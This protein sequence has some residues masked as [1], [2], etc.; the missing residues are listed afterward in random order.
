M[1]KNDTGET[2]QLFHSDMLTINLE[3]ILSLIFGY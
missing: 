1:Q 2:T 3:S